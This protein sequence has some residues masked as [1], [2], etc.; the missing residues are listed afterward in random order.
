MKVYLQNVFFLDSLNKKIKNICYFINWTYIYFIEVHNYAIF[1][2]VM[3]FGSDSV[4]VRF[5]LLLITLTYS[6]HNIRAY[7]SEY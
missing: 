2:Q 1:S 3:Y 5:C 4:P 7:L 6:T